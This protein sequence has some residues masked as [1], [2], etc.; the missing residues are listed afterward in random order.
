MVNRLLLLSAYRHLKGHPWQTWLSIIG[1]ALGVTVIVA[2]DLAN[3]SA[4]KA[5]LLSA[6]SLTGKAT[7][8]LVGG[9]DGIPERF[10]REL[11]IDRGV[12][13]SSPLVQGLVKLG[14]ERL[15]LIGVD[16]LADAG[17]RQF[18]PELSSNAARRLL[19]EYATVLLSS[20][21]AERLGLGVGDRLEVTI[22]GRPVTLHIVGLL[23]GDN[24]AVLEGLLLAD[25]S[26]AQEVLDRAGRL[27]RIDLILTPEQA[28]TLEPK[29]PPGLWLEVPESRT[30]VMM[31]MVEAFQTNLAAMSL[32]A[33]LVG[34]FLIYNTMTFSVL[35]R[36]HTLATLRILGVTRQSLFRLLLLEAAVLGVIGTALGL[37][38]GVLISHYLIQLVTRTINDLYFVLTVNQLFVAPELLLK[39][40]LIGISVTLLAALAPAVEA[41]GTVPVNALRRSQL[42][43]RVHHGLPWVALLGSITLLAGML[44][45]RQEDNGLIG[46]F[47]GLFLIIAG[48]SLMMPLVVTLLG[49]LSNQ[50]AHGGLLIRFALRGISAN[51]SRTGLSIAALSVAV[52]AT[53]GVSIMIS[54]FRSTVADWLTYTLRS[55]IYVSALSSRS[56]GSDGALLPDTRALID[57][58]PGVAETSGGRRTTINSEFGQTDLMAIDVA[59]LS[60]KGFQ[61]VN[62]PLA[63]VW[64]RYRRGELV[65]I[66][67]PYAFRHRLETGDSLLLHT[68]RGA[69]TLPIGGVFYDY[70][71]DQGLISLAQAAYAELWGDVA[72][73]TIGVFLRPGADSE[74]VSEEIRQALDPLQQDVS[75]RSNRQIRDYSMGIF[76]RTFAI[77]QVL[78]LLVIGVA[79]VGVLSALMALQLERTREQAVLRATGVTP[80]QIS[81]LTLLQTGL[82]GLYAGLLALPLG[83]LMSEVLIEV[84][85]RRSFGWSIMTRLPPEAPFEALFLAL[86][87]ALLAGLY[88]A[89]RMGKVQPA[90]ALREE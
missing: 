55:D 10:Y 71:S 63:D 3:Q 27:D 41:A 70:G 78:R 50:L 31:E 20:I 83:W 24:P 8:Q 79:F 67:E 37:G 11:R 14:P 9:P 30:R 85:N 53:L 74:R 26:T 21:T 44:L 28:R 52:A 40:S 76:D 38:L 82:M 2:V 56:N 15:R 61:F 87:A 89:W 60:N 18:V 77:T 80:G 54:S 64:P 36:R 68:P 12:H 29:L 51:L 48:Y 6:E 35:R 86:A 43:R 72:F 33:L 19:T 69:L 59:T 81:R 13:H 47:V 22:A 75:I 17:F 32:L 66:S 16:P 34:A 23:Q 4:R 46:G 65:L 25:I 49:R 45:V 42:E 58:V 73:S 39:G 57:A 88:P 62:P 7:H 84:I 90:R 5:F 1:I